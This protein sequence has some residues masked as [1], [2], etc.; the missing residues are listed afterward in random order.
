MIADFAMGAKGAATPQEAVGL[1]SLEDGER[2]VVSS[3]GSR[4]WILRPDG[5]AREAI[6]LT[7]VRGWVLHMREACV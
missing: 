7:H 5:T 4:V 3:Q 1:S 6:H 2:M